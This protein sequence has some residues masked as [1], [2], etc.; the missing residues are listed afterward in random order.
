[1]D[2]SWGPVGTKI[3]MVSLELKVEKEEGE[4]QWGILDG[5]F[6]RVLVGSS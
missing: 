3:G 5:N 6:K 4:Q 1:V 2:V